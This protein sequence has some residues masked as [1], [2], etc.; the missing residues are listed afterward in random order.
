MNITSNYFSVHF[1]GTPERETKE[2]SISPSELKVL[3]ALVGV[4]Y[5][6]LRIS[7]LR[8]KVFASDKTFS[9]SSVEPITRTLIEKG[10]LKSENKFVA[11]H[12]SKRFNYK[13]QKNILNHRGYLL[14]YHTTVDLLTVIPVEQLNKKRA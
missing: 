1:I 3:Q 2:F 10:L 4:P 5:P 7:E 12:A 11:D 6:G 9:T 8:T 13:R 14:H